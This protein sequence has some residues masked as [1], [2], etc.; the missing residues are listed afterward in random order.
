MNVRV[1]FTYPSILKLH[2]EK[3]NFVAEILRNEQK[4]LTKVVLQNDKV[5]LMAKKGS[6][7]EFTQIDYMK[8]FDEWNEKKAIDDKQE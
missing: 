6:D 5:V 1:E 7:H 3:A 4:M 8:F 2:Q